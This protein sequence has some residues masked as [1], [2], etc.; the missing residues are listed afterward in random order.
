[1]LVT[2]RATG[3]TAQPQAGRP[4]MGMERKRILVVDDDVDLRRSLKALL[5]A[6]GYEVDTASNGARA[7]ERQRHHP[8][9]ILIS[10]VFMP[11][12]DGLETIRAF[13][14]AYPQMRIVAISGNRSP[15]MKVD[16]LAVA[17]EV[18]ADAVLRKPF[19]VRDLLQALRG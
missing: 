15:R 1:M 12:A 4:A 3:K 5:E 7:L 14:L 8:A 11:E 17:G 18:G 16:Y 10:D 13:R 6:A 9:S 2:M 19:G